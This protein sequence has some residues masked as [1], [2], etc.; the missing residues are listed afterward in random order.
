MKDD[1]DGDGLP[2]ITETEGFRDG[3]GHWYTIDPNDPDT[4]G[5]GLSDGGEAGELVEW[6][7]PLP[8][9]R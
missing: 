7:A 2:D 3:Y 6:S 5:D 1:T 9:D 8:A 4:D